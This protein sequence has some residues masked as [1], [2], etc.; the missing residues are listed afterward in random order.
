[1]SNK[2]DLDPFIFKLIR[3]FVIQ[4]ASGKE[5]IS[6]DNEIKIMLTEGTGLLH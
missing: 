2:A 5:S 4:P 3:G 6:L 1:M